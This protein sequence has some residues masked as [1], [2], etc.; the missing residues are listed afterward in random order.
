[1][2]SVSSWARRKS[3]P[4]EG[5]VATLRL[6]G[7]GKVLDGSYTDEIV[8]VIDKDFEDYRRFFTTGAGEHHFGMVHQAMRKALEA[9]YP[10]HHQ[11]DDEPSGCAGDALV[12]SEK[13]T[14]QAALLT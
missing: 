1:M 13:S 2:S 10:G 14:L 6:E 12:V 8:A 11:T 5:I 4:A 9:T 3:P 7:R